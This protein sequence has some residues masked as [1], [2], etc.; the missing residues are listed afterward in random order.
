MTE[1]NPAANSAL[2]GL[3]LLERRLHDAVRGGGLSPHHLFPR[4]ARRS[5]RLYDAHRGGA[6]RGADPA[7]ERQS[8]RFGRYRGH[9]PAFRG[10]ARPVPE[11]LLSLRA[12]SAARSPRSTTRSRRAPAATSGS[13]SIAS[14]ARRS[15][16][17]TRWTRSSAPCAGT[18]SASAANTISTSSTSSPS[19]TSTWGRWR[20]RASTSSTTNTCW[21]TR[22]P[23]PTRT[24]RMSK[25]SSRTNIS[26]TGPATGSPAATGSSSA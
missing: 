20:T 24:T 3:Y 23:A 9:R 26:T 25:P 19:P 1:A 8:R 7:L 22:R 2:M 5:R 10:L 11:A 15:A 17:T 13:A 18:R 4:P 21:S 16:A 14:R 12:S 6:E